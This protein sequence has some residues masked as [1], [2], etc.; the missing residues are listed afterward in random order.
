[1][2]IGGES[3]EGLRA[4][5]RRVD[6]IRRR[7][8]FGHGTRLRKDSMV[9][10]AGLLHPEE[11]EEDATTVTTE[12][13]SDGGSPCNDHA[14]RH[15]GVTFSA[16]ADDGGASHS[17]L[18]TMMSPP[19]VVEVD[20]RGAVAP[21]TVSVAPRAAAGVAEPDGAA[22][23]LGEKGEKEKEGEEKQERED[24]EEEKEE[25]KDKKEGVRELEKAAEENKEEEE[26][27]G[28]RREVERAALRRG[29]ELR[30]EE[31]LPGS[32]S[33]RVYFLESIRECSDDDSV[34]EGTTAGGKVARLFLHDF[35]PAY[36]Q[37]PE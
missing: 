7:G 9:S 10:T 4:V 8:R 15:C 35:V 24:K 25:G 26:E 16:P 14:C 12:D 2:E 28:E 23:K 1:M 3:G 27:E 33:F 5:R 18:S 31:E 29:A 13:A 22:G 6:E 21:E 34:K 17:P 32:P 37:N 36:L 11:E 20:G 19:P 30:G